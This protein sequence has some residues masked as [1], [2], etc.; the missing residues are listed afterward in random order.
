MIMPSGVVVRTLLARYAAA[1]IEHAEK[2]GPA[3][4]RELADVTYT[5]CVI[6]N[7]CSIAAAL[8]LA[9]SVLQSAEGAGRPPAGAPAGAA[10]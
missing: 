7:S 2:P 10:S 6:T 9:D 1:R 4:S 8:A 5:L 3:T